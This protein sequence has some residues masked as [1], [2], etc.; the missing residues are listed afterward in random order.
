MASDE[1]LL[2][3]LYSCFNARNI[4]GAL[5]IM[6]PDIAWDSELEGP[7]HGK[8]GVRGYLARQWEMINSHAEPMR[9][10]ACGDGTINVE[11][12][13]TARDLD[14]NLLIEKVSG[15]SFQIENGLIRRFD[16]RPGLEA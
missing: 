16:V 3:H 2:S 10:S 1:D 8:D 15:H 12:R 7:V 6:H 11:V 5:A 14:G 9:Y 4:D 13:L